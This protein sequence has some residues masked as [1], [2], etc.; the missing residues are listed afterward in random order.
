MKPKPVS[1]LSGS[2]PVKISVGDGRYVDAEEVTRLFSFPR[3][4]MP[5]GRAKIKAK[6]SPAPGSAS[7]DRSNARFLRAQ[8]LDEQLI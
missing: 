3:A 4:E 7:N 8:G 5:E 2:I 6:T 1:D